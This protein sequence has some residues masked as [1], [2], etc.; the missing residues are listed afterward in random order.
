[1]LCCVV[2]YCV[3]LCC[4]VLCCVV[5]CCGIVLCGGIPTKSMGAL[6]DGAWYKVLAMA[7]ARC[8]L[9]MV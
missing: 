7:K 1:M 3:V 9:G 8:G 6:H 4:V 5:L 2:L